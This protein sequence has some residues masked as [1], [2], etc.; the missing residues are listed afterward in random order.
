MSPPTFRHLHT[1]DEQQARLVAEVR[2][3]L[4]SSPRWLPSSLFYDARGSALFERI[5]HLPEYYL[6]RTE[7]RI[8]SAVVPSL[9]AAR[10]PHELLELGSGSG[11]KIRRFLDAMARG[12]TL[13]RCVLLD[14]SEPA[15][16]ASG[17]ALGA[18]YP[19]LSVSALVGD[20]LHDLA[21]VPPGEARLG[22]FLGSTIGNIPHAQQPALLRALRATLQPGQA[23]LVGYDLVKDERMLHAAYNDAEGVTAEFNRNIL[24]VLGQRL[25]A[26]IDPGAF[27]HEA[28]WDPAAGWV[29]MRLRALSA[30][31]IALPGAGVEL[32]LEA[33][34]CVRTEVSCK[35]DRAGVER[36]LAGTGLA[37]ARWLTD[38]D[39][40]FALAELR[41]LEPAPGPAA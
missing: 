5:T 11:L 2:A 41:A 21:R 29:E 6:T 4:A 34:E 12:G 40:W 3:G 38:A 32:V 18:A 22:L 36:S 31:R 10:K 13:E 1:A 26:R 8:L 39:G 9:V 28:S 35:H 24:R 37:L 19:G 33:G 17:E 25:G 14:V 15:L 7:D 20:F 16:R 27:E 23:F 30:Q